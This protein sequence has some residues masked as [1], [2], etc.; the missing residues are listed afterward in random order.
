[1]LVRC[2]ASSKLFQSDAQLLPEPLLMRADPHRGYFD[3]RRVSWLTTS[4]QS[5]YDFLW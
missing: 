4:W 3:V 1:M 2:I 5:V